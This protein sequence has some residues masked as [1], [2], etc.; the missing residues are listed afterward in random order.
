ML[1]NIGEMVAMDVGFDDNQ[2]AMI[3]SRED[4]KKAATAEEG[5]AIFGTVVGLAQKTELCERSRVE[6]VN[7][8]A[9]FLE[10]EGD[11]QTEAVRLAKSGMGFEGPRL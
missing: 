2:L 7:Y 5:A 1:N 3:R 4:F 6:R 11:V 9:D 8:V 10:P